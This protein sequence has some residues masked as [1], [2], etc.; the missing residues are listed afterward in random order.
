MEGMLKGMME[1]RSIR[2]YAQRQ[3][4]DKALGEVFPAPKARKYPDPIWIR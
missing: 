4:P 2:K 3:I 1:R